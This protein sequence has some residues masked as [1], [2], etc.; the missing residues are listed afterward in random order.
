MVYCHITIPLG[1]TKIDIGEGK[2]SKWKDFEASCFP[3]FMKIE[4]AGCKR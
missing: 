4:M 1:M 3:L 2:S